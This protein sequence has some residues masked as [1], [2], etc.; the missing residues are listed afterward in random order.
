VTTT[1]KYLTSSGWAGGA[2]ERKLRLFACCCARRV[3]GL[4]PDECGRVA[5]RVAERFADG[6]AG[7][8]DLRAAYADA[9]DAAEDEGRDPYA[10]R[11]RP[12]RAAMCAAMPSRDA[13]DGQAR[14]RAF[15]RMSTR[16]SIKPLQL[17]WP[18]GSLA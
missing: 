6:L 14:D 3:W 7:D 10:V 16:A 18:F 12:G 2:T 1:S 5:V 8:E 13:G 9:H 11:P 17:S 15:S 4:F